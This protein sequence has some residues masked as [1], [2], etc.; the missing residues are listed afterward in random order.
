ME[1]PGFLSSIIDWVRRGYPD[2]VPDN[3]Y[4]PLF[5]LLGSQLSEAE[6]E[7]IADELALSGDAHSMEAMKQ[8]IH[9]ASGEPPKE[10]D[11]AR[12][13]ARLAAGGWPLAPPQRGP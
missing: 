7:E 1:L 2:G 8:A 13:R 4:L 9:G 6:I 11:I 3:D 12:V 5:A 10:V